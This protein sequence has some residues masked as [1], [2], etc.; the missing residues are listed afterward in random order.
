MKKMII[1]AVGFGV[2]WWGMASWAYAAI[3]EKTATAIIT[4]TTAAVA[5]LGEVHFTEKED[6]VQVAAHLTAVPAGN[7]G[8][9]IHEN[10]ACADS[11]KAAGGHFNPDN[12]QHGLL[13]K[14]SLEGAHAGDL[15]NIT[16][17]ADGSGDYSE[18][19]KGL[20]LSGGKYNIVGKAVIVHEKPDDFGQPTGNAGGRIGCGIIEINK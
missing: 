13:T 3:E 1:R 9:H 10:G 19:I 16:I 6:G 2:C 7:H 4:T 18:F 5:V 11:G 20:S 14:D 12:H 17:N 8:F 15:G